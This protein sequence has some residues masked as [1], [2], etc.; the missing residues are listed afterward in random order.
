[1]KPRL[2][3]PLL[4]AITLVLMA[5]DVTTGALSIPPA[6]VWRSLIHPQSA[7]PS[8]AL[9]VRHIRVVKAVV[10]L[11]AGMALSASGLQMQT[12]FRNPLAGPYVLGVSSGASLA[13]A[14]VM[15]WAGAAGSAFTVAAAA[16]VGSAAVLLLIAAASLR[17]RDV[18]QLLILGIMLSS[19]IG[20][21]VQI[22][23]YLSHEEALKAYVLWTMGS[24]GDVTATQLGV[25][26]PATLAGLLMAMATVKPLNMLLL[27]EDYARSMG[28]NLRLWRVVIIASTTLMAGTVTAFCGP[29]GFIGLAMPHLARAITANANH[30][31][32]LPA[33][34]L[35]GAIV[36][37]ACDILSKQLTLPINAI[38]SLV[39]IPVVVWVVIKSGHR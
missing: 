30:R 36:L 26:A 2:L 31:V 37:I 11:L 3:F 35:I 4:I 5:I 23:Q 13:V 6:Q 18:M 12:L 38:T 22:L 1:M 27:G 24:L 20:A 19:A 16:W 21:V 8:T 7:D 33:S 14:L 39:G 32:L 9:V 17:I 10:A 34:A 15:L 29:V 25:L 28:L